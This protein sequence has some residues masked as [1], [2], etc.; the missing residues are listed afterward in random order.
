MK[1]TGEGAEVYLCQN[2]FQNYI[3]QYILH[4]LKVV[5]VDTFDFYIV[6]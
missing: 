3:F 4:L 6:S 2:I 1:L 5:A